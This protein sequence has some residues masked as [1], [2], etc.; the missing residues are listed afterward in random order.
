MAK[1]PSPWSKAAAAAHLG[2]SV[3]TLERRI[4]DKSIRATKLGRLVRIPDS[5]VR[6]LAKGER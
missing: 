2:L 3:R 6:R 1:P 5:E 4:K